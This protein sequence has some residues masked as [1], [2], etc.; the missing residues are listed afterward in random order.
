M[1]VS[2]FIYDALVS[3]DKKIAN[4]K[5]GMTIS[6]FGAGRRGGERVQKPYCSALGLCPIR[7]A[8]RRQD[9]LQT[10]PAAH[11]FDQP[12]WWARFSLGGIAE[13]LAA[14]ALEKAGL[15]VNREVHVEKEMSGRIDLVARNDSSHVDIYNPIVIEVKS[16]STAKLKDHWAWQI[17]AY[18]ENHNDTIEYWEGDEA[19]C[20]IYTIWGWTVYRIR[21]QGGAGES[22]IY[23]IE[24][25]DPDTCLYDR[26]NILTYHSYREKLEAHQ[27]QL[28]S[29]SPGR[30]GRRLVTGD[31][32]GKRKIAHWECA[33]MPTTT[34]PHKYTKRYN[35]KRLQ[36][37]F[38]PGEVRLG[39]ATIRCE[40]FGYCYRSSNKS[41]TV[42]I[43][44]DSF[45]RAIL[46]DDNPL[47]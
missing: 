6:L 43:D 30:V 25:Y 19:Y 41:M 16:S 45:D 27:E 31:E 2:K 37:V 34:Q 18:M 10:H 17:V 24:R 28:H 35:H 33:H 15:A 11:A 23:H 42:A 40:Y 20:V 29:E 8:L 46:V 38:E 12:K 21:R 44:L 32:N 3:Q 1:D 36:R 4:L 39:E 26:E 9:K 22:A 5:G 7:Q 14:R 47:G 13:S